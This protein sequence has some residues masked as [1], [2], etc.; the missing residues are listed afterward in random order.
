MYKRRRADGDR[1]RL[2]NKPLIA[3][4]HLEGHA[5]TAR[6][7]AGIEFPY[8]L[9]LVS[10]GH[11]QLLSAAVRRDHYLLMNAAYG[12]ATGIAVES[13]PIGGVDGGR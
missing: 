10:G 12:D 9:L 13:R 3:V 6:L 1:V 7:T 2:A 8:L 11:C 5:L 4:N